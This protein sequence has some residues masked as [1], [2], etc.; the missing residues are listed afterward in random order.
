[1]KVTITGTLLSLL[2][3]AAP[4][5]SDASYL[6]RE[7]V[8]AFAEEMAQ[9]HGFDV[10][11]LFAAFHRAEPDP[12]VIRLITPSGEPAA[13]SWQRYRAR[14]LDASRIENGLAFWQENEVALREAEEESGLD[15]LT[16]EP[17]LFDIDRH[18]IPERGEV[19]GHWHYDARYVIHAGE[20]EDYV[21]SEESLDLAWRP[22]AALVDD[23]EA[24]EVMRRMAR[25]WLARRSV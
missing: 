1:M 9:K 8:R 17:E 19:P 13:R 3:L 2:L 4:A 7:D 11:E 21:V 20:R 6:E 25:K 23:L 18:W 12:R 15:G 16:I 24:D 14:F 22:I 10:A 5:H